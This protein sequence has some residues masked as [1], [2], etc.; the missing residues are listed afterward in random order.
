[1]WLRQWSTECQIHNFLQAIPV[2]KDNQSCINTASGNC[3][4]NNKRMKH[5]NIQLHFIKEI[6][7]SSQIKLIYTPTDRMLADFL[8]KSVSK[9]ILTRSLC[10]L[11]VLTL[12]ER[13]DVENQNSEF[14]SKSSNTQTSTCS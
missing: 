10:Q 5:V 11:G 2:H 14:T 9:P 3:N 8:T 12:E 4:L 13:G 1:M 7:Q 6:V